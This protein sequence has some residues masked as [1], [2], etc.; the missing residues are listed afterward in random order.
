M[1]SYYYKI[2]VKPEF[3][4]EAYPK[5]PGTHLFERLPGKPSICICPSNIQKVRTWLYQGP[6]ASK[7]WDQIFQIPCFHPNKG[8]DQLK[9]PVNENRTI[10]DGDLTVE[11]FSPLLRCFGVPTE[12]AI[13]SPIA[14]WKPGLAP[15]RKIIGWCAYCWSSRFYFHIKCLLSVWGFFRETRASAVVALQGAP[16][17]AVSVTTSAGLEPTFNH[18]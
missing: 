5:V 10:S 17:V 11:K 13:V 12:R 16:P 7:S 3:R 8:G 6:F 9:K 1:N 14:S 2:S 15:D 4:V 18:H